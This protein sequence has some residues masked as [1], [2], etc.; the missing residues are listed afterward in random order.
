MDALYEK[1]NVFIKKEAVVLKG[2]N[3]FLNVI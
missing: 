2:I 3:N 1:L